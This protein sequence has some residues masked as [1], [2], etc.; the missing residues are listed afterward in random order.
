MERVD[1]KTLLAFAVATV[2]LA[3]SV[4]LVTGRHATGGATGIAG[5]GSGA[6]VDLACVS[7][8]LGEIVRRLADVEH[9]QE[10]DLAMWPTV[11]PRRDPF[12]SVSGSAAAAVPAGT[13]AATDGGREESV[14][15]AVLLGRTG[16]V[17]IIDGRP[18]R[19]GDLLGGYTVEAIDQAGVWLRGEAGERTFLALS[20]NG[21]MGSVLVSVG[22]AA[23]APTAGRSRPEGERKQR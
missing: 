17:A 12:R 2:L 9:R 21:G 19:V 14:C 4:L 10:E 23:T 20:D 22:S 8:D 1:R 3:G 16:G 11:A 6:E 18:Y 7:T 5:P 15:S 13:V